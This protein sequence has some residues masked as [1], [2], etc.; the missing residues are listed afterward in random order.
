MNP[1]D[2]A[3]KALAVL[4]SDDAKHGRAPQASLDC[5]RAL[6]EAAGLMALIGPGTAE[7]TALP[8]TFWIRE[9][10]PAVD[11]ICRRC[12]RP[13]GANVFVFLVPEEPSDLEAVADKAQGRA[14]TTTASLRHARCP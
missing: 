4:D 13:I 1:D 12:N 9:D 11:H 2:L 3:R 5:A 6:L 10:H 7:T 8:R 14:Y